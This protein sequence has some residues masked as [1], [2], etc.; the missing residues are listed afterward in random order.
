M[1]W[2]T[3]DGREYGPGSIVPSEAGFAHAGAII[4]YKS[5]NITFFH[6]FCLFLCSRN[7]KI[8]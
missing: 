6:G 7:A 2:A 1:S 4:D 5:S 3:H 8:K